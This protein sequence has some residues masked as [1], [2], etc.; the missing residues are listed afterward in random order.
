MNSSTRSRLLALTLVLAAAAPLTAADS[1]PAIDRPAQPV[2]TVAPKYPY[3]MRHAAAAAEVTV[4]FTVN[5]KGA[6][7]DAKIVDSTSPEF[8]TATLDALKKWQFTPALKDGKPVDTRVV[9]TFTF[10]VRSDTE[11]T[12][13]SQVAVKKRNQ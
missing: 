8:V 9:Q 7:T 3:M 12:G 11:T 10:N 4:L 2:A 6:V 13:V 5:A 1:A